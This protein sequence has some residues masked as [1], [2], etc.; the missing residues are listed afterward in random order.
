MEVNYLVK[1]SVIVPAYNEEKFIAQT[2]QELSNYLSA[3]FGDF[4]IVVVSDGSGDATF[5]RAQ[6]LASRKVRVYEYQPNQGKGY[7]LK[8]GFQ[9]SRGEIIIF[10]DAGLDF[11]PCQIGEFLKIL[12]E[13]KADVLIGS[14]RHPASKVAYPFKRRLISFGGQVLVKTLF[15]LSVRDTQVGLKV[16][17][18][19][20]LKAVMPRV[21]VKRYAFDVELLALAHH[22][23]FKI[24]E[25]PVDLNLRF[26]TAGTTRSVLVTL[27]DTLSIFYRLK[28]IKFYDRTRE[29]RERI[30]QEYHPAVVDRILR[31]VSRNVSKW[32]NR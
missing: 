30:L 5:K 18:R 14:K 16:F 21:L 19:E 23:G 9:K 12:Q 7:A 3:E 32:I 6:N 20:V 15:N 10:Y 8:F 28:I 2:I 17:K 31:Y 25:A 22:Y 29:E 27:V 11:P 24:K 1:L 4:E 13:S 26:S